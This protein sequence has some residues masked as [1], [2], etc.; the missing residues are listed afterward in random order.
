MIGKVLYTLLTADATLTGIVSTRVY[1]LL[2]PQTNTFPAIGYI[3]EEKPVMRCDGGTRI[4]MADVTLGIFADTLLEAEN[5]GTHVVR[6]LDLQRGTIAGVDVQSIMLANGEDDF[7]EELRIH[8]VKQTY[9]ITY[10]T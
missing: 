4:I 5:I 9:N 2:L 6:I 8:Y 10:L 3:V 1:P 7:D